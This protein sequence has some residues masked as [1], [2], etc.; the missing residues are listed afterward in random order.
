MMLS[1]L[2]F[3]VFLGLRTYSIAGMILLIKVVV[4]GVYRRDQFEKKKVTDTLAMSMLVILII[5][6]GQLLLSFKL[7]VDFPGFISPGGFH[8]GGLITNAP[9]HFDSF[10][11]DCSIF[12]ICYGITGVR[13]GQVKAKKNL[14][15]F[16][17]FLVIFLAILFVPY[18][19][20]LLIK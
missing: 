16:L 6:L 2:L 11:F 18:F 13:L 20:Y 4:T 10:L 5:N 15:I 7:P 12:G 14:L 3:I 8:N 1:L 9:L 19:A 17:I